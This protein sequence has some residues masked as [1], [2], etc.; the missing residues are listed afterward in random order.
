MMRL[1]KR[2]CFIFGFSFQTPRVCDGS[3][4]EAVPFDLCY[5][6]SMFVYIP[7]SDFGEDNQKDL[8]AVGTMRIERSSNN[9]NYNKDH[10][11]NMT[12]DNGIIIEN[13]KSSLNPRYEEDY[14]LTGE[15]LDEIN[16]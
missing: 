1:I 8:T 7:H 12:I 9:S 5:S 14:Y 2:K 11:T 6:P 16:V 4:G 13:D 15:E 3:Y 10:D